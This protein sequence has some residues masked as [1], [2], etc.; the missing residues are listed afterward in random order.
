MVRR[1][2]MKKSSRLS[3]EFTD[4]EARRARTYFNKLIKILE[5]DLESSVRSSSSEALYAEPAWAEHQA[6]R[7][8]VQR[9]LRKVI[10][11]I[12][13]RKE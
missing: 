9:T 5:K 11:L 3:T 10:D 12:T 7:L 8:G 1:A 6:D 13:I 2:L 4:V